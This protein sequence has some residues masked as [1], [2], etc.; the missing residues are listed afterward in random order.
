MDGI[1][2]CGKCNSTIIDEELT[3]HRCPR[4]PYV[5]KGNVLWAKWYD[6]KW[7][8]YILPDLPHQNQHT[9][10]THQDSTMQ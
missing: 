2:V 4:E 1:R 3:K 6:G 8:K 7:Y 5:L 10:G 9:K